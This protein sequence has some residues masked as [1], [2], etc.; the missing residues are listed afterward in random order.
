MA[1]SGSVTYLY[2]LVKVLTHY[3]ELGE[4]MQNVFLWKSLVQ[5]KTLYSTVYPR[6]FDVHDNFVFLFT[7]I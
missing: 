7:L 5:K 1:V 6:F 4:L 2:C 3:M